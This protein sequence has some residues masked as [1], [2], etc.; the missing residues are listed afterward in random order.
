MPFS[1]INTGVLSQLGCALWSWKLCS[2]CLAGSPCTDG[3]CPAYNTGRLQRFHQ[4]YKAVVSGYEDDAVDPQAVVFRT[5]EDLFQAI[6]L[7]R[8]N[9]GK[10]RQEFS[11]LLKGGSRNAGDLF[12]ATNLAAKVL[13]MIDCSTSY[14]STD[15]LEKG[16]FRLPWKDDSA[17]SKYL[18]GLFPTENHPIFS[19]PDSEAFAD[20]KGELMG[21]RLKKRLNLKFRP[22]HD[23][24]NHLRLDRRSNVLEI[25]HYTSFIKEQL[26]VDYSNGAAYVSEFSQPQSKPKEKS[27]GKC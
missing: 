7:L 9:P 25:Y 1:E 12:R 27:S 4:F 11:G 13:T 6:L 2:N 18:Q 26:K 15:R 3:T 5:H 19:Y 24:R 10:T 21:R 20:A 22:T 23:I 14:L 8:Q 16:N 17:F